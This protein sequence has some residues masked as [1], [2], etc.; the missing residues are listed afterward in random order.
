VFGLVYALRSVLLPFLVGLIFAYLL[1][2][3]IKRLEQK[4]P[5]KGQRMGLKRVSLIILTYISALIL[6]GLFTVYV[7]FGV[8][9]SF[10]S[11]IIQAP[12]Y[13]S[14]GL[15]AIQQW[16]ESFRQTLPS[17]Y[18]QQVDNVINTVGD[19][20]GGWLQNAF[21]SGVSFIPATF[22]MIA[23]FISLP[24]FLFF[25][26]KDAESLGSGFYSLLPTGMTAVHARN[27]FKIMDNVLG[28]Y[29]RA[30]LLLGAVVGSLV[31]IGLTA[32]QIPLA[33]ALAVFA[34][35]MEVIP[36]VGPWIAAIFGVL[37]ALALIPSKIIWVALV[38]LAANLL[39]NLLLAPRIHGGF[40][41]INPAILMV[42]LVLGAYL[43]GIWGMILFPPLTA[44]IV[45]VYKYIRVNV[46]SGEV[47]HPVNQ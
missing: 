17:Q 47:Q 6:I 29:I 35:I 11:I 44:L 15:A 36:T 26:L 23:G 22:G 45:E 1:L 19:K 25:V 42:V 21:V 30:Q 5:N 8:R 27:I 16:F 40:L 31:F 2:P 34:A 46:G 13:I 33:P 24:F 20:A 18:Q 7:Y 3:V 38:Y 28:K 14:D 37:V 43:A 10:S 9:Q 4:F 32:L 12:Q 39:E 41:R